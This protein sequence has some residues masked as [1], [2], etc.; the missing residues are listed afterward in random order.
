MPRLLKE[1]TGEKR[2]ASINAHCDFVRRNLIQK[3]TL[4]EAQTD[5][6]SKFAD[7][8]LKPPLQVT[9]N[10][11]TFLKWYESYDPDHSELWYYATKNPKDAEFPE[12]CG[13]A[14]VNRDRVID[15]WLIWSIDI[16][17]NG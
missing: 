16:T 8:Q 6:E 7:G 3:I 1:K 12:E 9:T 17:Y 4:S 15:R 10:W 5:I 11:T 14:I 2:I 13:Y